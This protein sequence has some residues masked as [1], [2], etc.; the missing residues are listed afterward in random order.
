MCGGSVFQAAKSD[1][2]GKRKMDETGIIV[3]SCRHGVI[4]GA[5]N[6]YH[7]E[8]YTHTHF[9]HKMCWALKCKYFCYDVVCRYWPFATEVGNKFPEFKGMTSEMQGMLPICH[10]KAHSYECQV[11]V[12]F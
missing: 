4:L 1:S 7:G 5:I 11:T 10:A 2:G 9:I 6:M 8:T 12:Y 3:S